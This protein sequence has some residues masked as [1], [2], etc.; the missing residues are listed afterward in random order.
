MKKYFLIL[1]FLLSILSFS[2]SNFSNGFKDGY[3]K[4]YCYNQGVGCIPP[5]PPIAPIPTVNERMNSYQDGYN[6]GFETGL[7]AQKK[8]N[9][10]SN[11]TRERYQTSKSEY[12]DDAIYNPY[13]DTQTLNL[14]IKVAELKSKRINDLY[15]RGL[16]SYNND[17]F[18]DA[19]YYTNEI[20][21]IDASIPQVYALKA[22]SQL[23]NNEIL[24]SYNNISKADRLNYSGNENIN[25]INKEV[26]EYINKQMAN[27]N[28]D[29]VIYFCNNSWYESDFTNYFLGLGYYYKNDF[30]NA[31]KALKKVKNSDQVKEYIESINN[32]TR[33][34]N[35]YLNYSEEKTEEEQIN[36]VSTKNDGNSNNLKIFFDEVKHLYENRKF[37]DVITLI[38]NK[39]NIVPKDLKEGWEYLYSVRGISNYFQK[40]Y[41]EAISDITLS[42]NNSSTEYPNMI[43]YRAL[44]KS[45]VK[46]YYGAISDCD[47]LIKL[48]EKNKGTSYD[49]ATIY[50]NKAYALTNLKKYNEA[51]PLVKKALELNN[52]YWYIWDTKG[53]IE[54]YL[55]NYNQCIQDMSQAIKIKKDANSF[56]F[57]GLSYHKSG[58]KE[59][60][61][62]DLS[63][64][65]EMGKK[66]AYYDIN[67]Y[68]K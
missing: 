55:G 44:C 31:K 33:I 64:S 25:V 16:E 30:K 51:L 65:G 19:I 29:D 67:K 52:S 58:K 23:Y 36:S 40:N 47:I 49:L 53:E 4:G 37:N 24:N 12:V 9:N 60:G 5:I 18:S 68:C 13:K 21:K 27:Q 46:D 57:R 8:S 20:I 22:M 34:P 14:A 2:Q 61:C 38:D 45:E 56:Y 7:E 54:Y 6:R 1:S 17:N 59:L 43:F 62:K 11:E 32:N 48:G 28:F 10:N 41:F 15:E 35:P 50:N 3:K 26:I 63:T 42:I 39:K 66:E